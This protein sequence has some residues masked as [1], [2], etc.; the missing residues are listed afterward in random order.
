MGYKSELQ[1]ENEL[2]NYLS[3]ALITADSPDTPLLPNGILRTRNWE[4]MPKLNTEEKLWENFKKILEQHN[5]QTLDRPLSYTE[6][7]QVKKLSVI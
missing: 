7:E 5:S 2:I 3:N 1:F 6:F 4:Y